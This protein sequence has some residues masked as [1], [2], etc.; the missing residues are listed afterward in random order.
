MRLGDLEVRAS[1]ALS[2]ECL[3]ETGRRGFRRLGLLGALVPEVPVDR[4]EPDAV[5]GAAQ[6]AKAIRE[7]GSR[8]GGV[9]VRASGTEPVIR[10]MVEADTEER[11]GEVADRLVKVVDDELSL[12]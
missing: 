6:Q 5:S 2:Y 11:A 4:S 9:L 1:L 8:D 7:S 3:D 10:V 12:A